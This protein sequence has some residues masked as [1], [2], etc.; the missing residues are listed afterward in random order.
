MPCRGA[1]VIAK[2]IERFGGG[3]LEHVNKTMKS[4]AQILDDA[5]KE[6]INLQ[7]HDLQA[8]ARL[9]YPYRIGGPGLHGPEGYKVHIQ[10]G[11]MISAK[12]S[13]IK[14]ASINFG[15]LKAGAYAGVDEMK[16]PHALY[17]FWG[18]SKM[19][20]RNFLDPALKAAAEPAKAVLTQNLRNFV[21]NFKP[22]KEV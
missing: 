7:D 13:G 15:V 4:V 11:Q 1:D 10:S 22:I 16:A 5:V 12:I 21:F 8:L 18:T 9:D 17:V 20:P 14:E 19:I 6:N 2:N 3:F